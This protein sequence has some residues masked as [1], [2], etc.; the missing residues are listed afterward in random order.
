VSPASA[1]ALAPAPGA[2]FTGGSEIRIAR[3]IG[4][5]NIGGPAI[6]A[7]TMTRELE[8]LGYRTLLLRGVEAEHEGSMDHLARELGVRPVLVPGMQREIGP[9]ELPALARLV[10]HLRAFRPHLVHTHAAKAGTLGR[11]AA[12]I[13]GGP[14]RPAIVHTFHGHSLE[15]YF[16]PIKARVFLEIERS[17]ARASDRLIAV[18]P[19]VRD[20][21]VR[22]GVAPA[23]QFTVIPLGFDLS[24]FD[25][26]GAVRAER[27]A[28]KRLEWGVGPE[29]RV[30][31]L[32]A[33]LVPIKRVDR[34]LR[35]AAVLAGESSQLRF[36]IV[37]DGELRDELRASAAALRLGERVVWTGFDKDVP[38][39]YAAS[40]CVALTSDNEGT[41]VSLIEAQAAGL[42]VVSTRVGGVAS[43][44]R[45]GVTG[46]LVEREDHEA[47]A[48]A[49]RAVLAG[50]GRMGEAG[51]EEVFSRFSQE[52]LVD[53]LHRLYG[54][55]LTRR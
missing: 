6:Q 25:L 53:D 13:A 43:A 32:V 27:R 8:P 51:R 45:D 35:I 29:E 12:V 42:G 47:F 46:M 31:T 1:S 33:R 9:G 41:P 44:I 5:L 16:S 52:R 2:P 49:V 38:S 23:A 48:A 26:R 50:G 4:R 39:V 40:D 34:F 15:E 20:D 10:R 24:R 7:I 55:I 21:L 28:A 19:E 3:I 17:L 11:T 22:L 18:S 37:G 54:E 14:R 36:V 30:V